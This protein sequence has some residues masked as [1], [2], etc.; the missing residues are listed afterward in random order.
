MSSSDWKPPE[1]HEVRAMKWIDTHAHYF[2]PVFQDKWQEIHDAFR[3]CNVQK[4]ICP[5][6]SYSSNKLMTDLFSDHDDI[7]FAFGIHP[8]CL[9]DGLKKPD[10]KGQYPKYDVLKNNLIQTEKA[11]EDIHQQ[12]NDIKGLAESEKKVAAIGETGLDYSYKPSREEIEIQIVTFRMQIE[13]ALKLRLPL[14]LHIRDAHEDG[15]RILKMYN[16]HYSGVI[17][18]FNGG[19][20]LAD[21][22]VEL[23]FALGIGGCLTDSRYPELPDAVAHTNMEDLV[24]ETDAP[25]LIPQG[26]SDTFSF[27]TSASIPVIGKEVA[28]LRGTG[29]DE[30]AEITCRNAERIFGSISDGHPT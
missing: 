7:F 26:M 22:Y 29:I 23:G 17:H 21:C 3:K 9:F 5:A 13:L 15:L 10:P 16:T 28:R 18:C 30:V 4:A 2:L 19:R 14:I 8:K 6:I 24:L 1:I 25:Y 12:I 11:L 27:N 20:E